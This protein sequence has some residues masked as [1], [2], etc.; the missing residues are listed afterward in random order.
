MILTH[1]FAF[2]NHLEMID[3]KSRE[4]TAPEVDIG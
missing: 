3:H 4:K 2:P 1:C